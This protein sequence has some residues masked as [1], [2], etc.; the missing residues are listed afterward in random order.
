MIASLAGTTLTIFVRRCLP[1]PAYSF[2]AAWRVHS[3][4]GPCMLPPLP[5]H[6]PLCDS[7]I[8]MPQEYFE[9]WKAAKNYE[10]LQTVKRGDAHALEASRAR[11]VSA[12]DWRDLAAPEKR[13][14]LIWCCTACCPRCGTSYPQ[15]RRARRLDDQ[16]ADRRLIGNDRS[17]SRDHP[18][19]CCREC[20]PRLAQL[21]SEQ[22]RMEHGRV[23]TWWRSLVREIRESW[24]R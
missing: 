4:W 15:E 19:D 3:V 17:A 5:E 11:C 23:K 12:N 9:T 13:E 24:K 18:M 10:L 7:S 6:C 14:F 22:Y 20:D 1:S 2:V 8:H 21:E 16:A